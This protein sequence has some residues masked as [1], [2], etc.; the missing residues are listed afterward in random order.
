MQTA[1]K[2]ARGAGAGR[3]SAILR[4][5][6]EAAARIRR[7]KRYFYLLDGWTAE[8]SHAEYFI[9]VKLGRHTRSGG[10][11]DMTFSMAHHGLVADLSMGMTLAPGSRKAVIIGDARVS[12]EFVK[13]DLDKGR[14]FVPD[15]TARR[16]IS[17]SY[18]PML[19]Y[20]LSWAFL[21]GGVESALL[22]N[23]DRTEWDA[24]RDSE[25][26][27]IGTMVM[28][29]YR[30][31]RDGTALRLDGLEFKAPDTAKMAGFL[32]RDGKGGTARPLRF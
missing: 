31:A 32:L 28:S 27:Y 8:G 10:G 19:A 13:F 6:A 3:D 26:E 18:T 24:A 21:G 12:P 4:R 11:R 14:F 2:V 29:A 1:E 25:G 16:A 5:A 7:E 30:D 22:R 15:Q 9:D 20:L 23:T 17:E